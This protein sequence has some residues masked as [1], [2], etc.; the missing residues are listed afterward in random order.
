[1]T[2]VSSSAGSGADGIRGPR[3]H[4]GPDTH[5]APEPAQRSGVVAIPAHART[6]PSLE[7]TGTARGGEIAARAIMPDAGGARTS[8][9]L[10]RQ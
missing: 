7:N 10:E 1:M 2:R 5:H 9:V 3:A 4:A 6:A 8:R